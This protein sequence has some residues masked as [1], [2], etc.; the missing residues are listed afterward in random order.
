MQTLG[1]SPKTVESDSLGRGVQGVE[2]QKSAF[3]TNSTGQ[4]QLSRDYF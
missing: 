2:V 4:I 1:P 3:K